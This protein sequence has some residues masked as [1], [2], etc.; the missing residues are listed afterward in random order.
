MSIA[1]RTK[2]YKPPVPFSVFIS[3]AQKDLPTAKRFHDALTRPGIAPFL[4]ETSV[5]PGQSLDASIHEAIKSADIFV[6]FWSEH[7]AASDWVRDELGGAR[8]Q[9]KQII[10]V[11]LDPEG[12]AKLPAFLRDTKHVRAYRDVDEALNSVEEQVAC[13]AKEKCDARRSREL[14]VVALTLVGLAALAS[15]GR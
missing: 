5:H 12:V 9:G 3:Y 2:T 13:A 8:Q 7:A 4:A 15:G 11:V 10:P 1:A 6:L 14:G